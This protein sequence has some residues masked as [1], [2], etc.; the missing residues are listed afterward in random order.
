[1]FK[2]FTKA[3]LTTVAVVLGIKVG[4]RISDKL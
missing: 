4:L 3:V 1:M 2:T